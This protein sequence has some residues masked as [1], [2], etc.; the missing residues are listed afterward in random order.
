MNAAVPYPININ[1][2]LKH[3]NILQRSLFSSRKI[4]VENKAQGRIPSDLEFLYMW[5]TWGNSLEVSVAP[6]AYLQNKVASDHYL[7]K[8]KTEDIINN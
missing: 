4:T 5:D 8:K 2:I 3:V 6:A 7:N 1:R